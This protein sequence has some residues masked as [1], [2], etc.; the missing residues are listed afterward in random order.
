MPVPGGGDV[1]QV[2]WRYSP[3]VV[4]YILSRGGGVG[5]CTCVITVGL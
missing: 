4:M 3:G 1:V 5:G 2:E